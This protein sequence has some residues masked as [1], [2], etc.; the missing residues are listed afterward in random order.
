MATSATTRRD[1]GLK[2]ALK[3]FFAPILRFLRK[4][5]DIQARII[6]A[7]FYFLVLAPFALFVRW[8]RDPLALKPSTP[9][10]WRPREASEDPAARAKEQF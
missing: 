2:R 1:G 5:G 9:K 10:G 7:I 3:S 6:L 8:R 4:V